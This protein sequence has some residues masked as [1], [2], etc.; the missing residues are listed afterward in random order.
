MILSIVVPCYNEA[1]NIPLLLNRFND[2]IKSREIEVVIVDNGSTDSTEE[3]LRRIKGDYHFTTTI[4]IEK[5]Q[6]YGYG[7]LRGLE[8]CKGDFI[9]WTHADMQTDP[10]DVIKALDIIQKKDFDKKIYV[11]GNR[12]GRPFFDEFFTRGMSMFETVYLG[13]KLVDVNAQPNIFHRS[14]FEKWNNPPNDFSLDLYALYMAKKNNLDIHR[15]S[16]FF[17]KR[18][19]GE[20]KWNNAGLIS[21]W[22]FIS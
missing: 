16:V 19:Y 6:G 4:R 2:V 7:I 17:P 12:K 1:E 18:I 15:F 13:E 14:F 5:N 21:K 10:G 11:K 3:L 8:V 22:R 20:S 9:G